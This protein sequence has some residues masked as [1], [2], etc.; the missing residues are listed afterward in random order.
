MEVFDRMA[1][2]Q[3]M[4]LFTHVPE[5]ALRDIAGQLREI[6]AP[7]GRVLF[8]E[9]DP[10]D[11]LYIIAEGSLSIE[12]RDTHLLSVGPG[13]CV[14]EYALIDDAPRSASVSV[15][16][17][18]LLL[19]W[20]R[21]EFQRALSWSPDVALGL[22]KA[23]IVKLRRNVLLE[24]EAMLERDRMD[25][26][27]MRAREIQMAMLP[28]G[29]Y[30][31]DRV[32]ISG[33]CRPAS[34]VGGD[35]YDYL[36]R[37]RSRLGIILGDVTGHEFYSG[38][39]VAMA[40]S[41]LH[42]HGRMDDTPAR[43]MESMNRA[44]S[45]SIQSGVLMMTCCYLLVDMNRQTI[46]YT[47]AGHNPPFFY[48]RRKEKLEPLESTDMVLGVPGFQARRFQQAER[49]W[50]RGDLLV[51]YSDGLTEAVDVHGDMFEEERV[52]AILLQNTDRSVTEIKRAIL[53]AHA[54]HCEGL[55]QEDDVTLVVA[56]AL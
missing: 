40:K 50:V 7:R 41:C 52:G 31:T 19:S 48:S 38:L 2:L 15:E 23:L 1:F 6:R 28:E 32:A 24:T 46:T 47:N 51:V 4:D 18:A 56:R 16:S 3:T 22:M 12:R 9:G 8:R 10:G 42:T 45:L 55:A 25:R 27:L 37:D 49:P 53:E 21:A 43:I 35:Y 36:V 34:A 11:L 26:D 33:Y 29:D 20:G 14:G 17:D 54:A 13:G 5:V 39:F 44:L 30:A